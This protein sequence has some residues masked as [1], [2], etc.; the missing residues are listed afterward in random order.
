MEIK[1]D[2]HKD[3]KEELKQIIKLLQS[4]VGE[5]NSE[6]LKEK[7]RDIFSDEDALTQKKY[8]TS[9]SYNEPITKEAPSEDLFNI[10]NS[11]KKEDIEKE[12]EREKRNIMT[13]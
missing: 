12:P 2:T 3:S 6:E 9:Q 5:I 1:I 7:P 11:S 8:E 4:I 10:F 13:Y